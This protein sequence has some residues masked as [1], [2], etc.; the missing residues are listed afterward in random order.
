MN[1]H[2]QFGAVSELGREGFLSQCFKASVSAW[3]ACEN[4]SNSDLPGGQSRQGFADSSK[5]TLKQPECVLWKT[6][7]TSASHAS[8]VSVRLWTWSRDETETETETDP[9]LFY[10]KTWSFFFC[11]GYFLHTHFV[12]LII[13]IRQNL[14]SLCWMQENL[15]IPCNSNGS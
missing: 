1:R 5:Q 6:P 10:K 15:Y 11:L 13:T 12:C 3:K 8:E 4:V 14:G 2:F 7:E 9:S